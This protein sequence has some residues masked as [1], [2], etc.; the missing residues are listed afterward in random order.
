MS[1]AHEP[2]YPVPLGP[3]EALD[4]EMNP[5]GL[6]KREYLAAVA[7]QGLTQSAFKYMSEGEGHATESALS[8]M[9]DIGKVSCDMADALLAELEKT[10]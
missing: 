9:K 7:M 6:T 3:G 2:A 10:S 5:N 4:D 8:M 1:K